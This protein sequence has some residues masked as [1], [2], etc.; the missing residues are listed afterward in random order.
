MNLADACLGRM[1]ETFADPMLVATG[2]DFRIGRR[3]RR[4][5]VPSTTPY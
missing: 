5:V 3:H 1:R 2:A 4:Q